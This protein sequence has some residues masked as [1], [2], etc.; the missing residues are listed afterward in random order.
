[1]YRYSVKYRRDDSAS[2]VYHVTVTARDADDARRVAAEAD[3]R[4]RSTVTSPR[5]GARILVESEAHR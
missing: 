1:M 3:P 2:R 4:Y 5:R